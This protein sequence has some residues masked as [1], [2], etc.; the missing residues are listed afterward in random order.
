MMMIFKLLKAHFAVFLLFLLL[1]PSVTFSQEREKKK[2]ELLHAEELRFDRDVDPDK[3]ILTGDVRFK[4]NK[5]LLFCDTAFLFQ[6]ANRVEAF[7]SIHIKEEDDSLNIY[8]KR[9]YYNG[10]ERW[11]ELHDSVLLI[12]KGMSLRTN[13]L[14]YD[15]KT[16]VASYYDGGTIVDSANILTSI[17][18]YYHSKERL[19]FFKDSVELV[20][21]DYT[22][23]SDTLKYL[24]DTE[25]AHFFGPTQIISQDNFIFCRNGWYDTKNDK[26]Q[27]NNHAYLRNKEKTLAGDSLYYDRGSGF[28]KAIGNI[29]FTDTVRNTIITGHYSEYFEHSDYVMVTDSALFAL[30]EKTDT[31]F[32]HADTLLSVLLE[33]PIPIDSLNI[34]EDSLLLIGL[35]TDTARMIYAYNHV[36]FFRH[37]VQ[38]VADSLVYNLR[39][40][41]LKCFGNPV[42]WNDS[43]QLS[44]AYIEL[45][46]GEERIDSVFLDQSAF[47]I[48]MKDSLRFDQISG[49]LMWGYFAENELRLLNVEGSSKTV[50]YVED[51]LGRLIGVNKADAENLMLILENRS[52]KSISFYINPVA[53]MYPDDIIPSE[54]RKLENF[55][56][57]IDIRPKSKYDIFQH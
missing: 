22:M 9:L 41:I 32:L 21:I 55:Q 13:H 8:A 56:W 36:K 29:S 12:D 37:D 54:S 43:L 49:D 53:V 46:T 4:H 28:G 16:K 33:F 52:F 50:Y 20:N 23:Y 39:D 18:G 34:P 57:L 26:C 42:I 7:G 19:L 30:V 5:T 48:I 2:I 25:V 45:F 35:Q 10:D 51:E 27:F 47:I 17:R 11:A 24:T 14:E 40:S 3:R 38:G 44:A 1:I 6:E 15:M 31:F